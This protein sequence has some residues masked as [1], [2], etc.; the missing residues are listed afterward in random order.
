MET[1]EKSRRNSGNQPAGGKLYGTQLHLRIFRDIYRT[2]AEKQ[3]PAAV[4][5]AGS[6]QCRNQTGIPPGSV[7]FTRQP[8]IRLRHIQRI[9]KFSQRVF[10]KRSKRVQDIV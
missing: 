7:E 9:C 1:A 6:F 3:L 4:G 8:D 2:A 10:P 5:I